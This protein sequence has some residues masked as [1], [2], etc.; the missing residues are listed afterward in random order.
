MDNFTYRNPT[1]LIFGKGR[2]A[3]LSQEIA[4]GS[5]VLVA[6]GGGSIRQNGV[7]DQ[8]LS[9]LQGVE[10][11]E[12]GGIEANP[13]F[14]TLM[15]AVEIVRQQGVQFILSVGGGSV[16]DGVKFI[17]A[18]AHLEGDPW[19]I[20]TGKAE[21]KSAI[22]I[23]SVLTL[24]GTGSEMNCFS[25]ISRRSTNEKLAFGNPLV[26]P[27]F[28][29]LDPETTYSLPKRQI[30]N[31]VADAFVHVIEQ[32][33]TYPSDAPLQDRMAESVL[34][35]LIEEGPKTLANP[36][37]YT[38][39]AN[40]MW[41]ATMA[42]NGIISVGVPQ[43]WA[44]HGIGHELTALYGLDHARTLAVVLPSLLRQ[45]KDVK[46][47]KLVQFAERVWD[48]KTGSADEKIEA[49]IQKTEGFFLSLGIPVKLSAH[50]IG[51]EAAKRVVQNLSRRGEIAL[52]EDGKITGPVVEKILIEAV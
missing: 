14:D 4:P 17:A 16:L 37:D 9:A 47:A 20:L 27:V 23:G 1:K 7:Y 33:L 36:D 24:P 39:R 11:F 30:G 22:P 44:T 8:V 52:G 40:I 32:Y 10:L 5:K 34:L 2:I 28:S 6:Y 35:T 19:T 38:S 46:Q 15:K 21:I 42:L 13:D 12:F 26:Y 51:E 50:Q 29:I 41:A 45:R 25:V 49:A 48:F 43:D 31:G 3:E 18:A